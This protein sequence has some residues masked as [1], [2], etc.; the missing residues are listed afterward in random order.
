MDCGCRGVGDGEF[1]EEG[2]GHFL[3]RF[4]WMSFGL[5][6]PKGYWVFLLFCCF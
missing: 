6:V 3:F 1:G 5:D 2:D 4:A